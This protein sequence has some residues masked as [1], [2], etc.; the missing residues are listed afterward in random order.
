MLVK[1]MF[2]EAELEKFVPEVTEKKNGFDRGNDG[3]QE[4]CLLQPF[5]KLMVR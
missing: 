1:E 3:V 5:L 2:S 4:V